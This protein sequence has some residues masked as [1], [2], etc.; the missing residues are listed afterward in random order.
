[1]RRLFKKKANLLVIAISAATVLIPALAF[2][3]DDVPST[4]RLT[5]TNG[6]IQSSEVS[7][8]T[9]V[10]AQEVDGT[11]NGDKIVFWNGVGITY[12]WQGKTADPSWKTYQY[13]SGVTCDNKSILMANPAHPQ[14]GNTGAN[15]WAN[16][17]NVPGVNCSGVNINLNKFTYSVEVPGTI[18]IAHPENADIIY[19][20]SGN[21][22]VR[23]DGDPGYVFVPSGHANLK[24]VF[25]KQN[26]LSNKCPD[27][28]VIDPSVGDAPGN[29]V[30]YGMQVGNGG[31]PPPTTGPFAP[32]AASDCTINPD[33]TNT[34]VLNSAA[35]G[36]ASTPNPSAPKLANGSIKLHI[37]GVNQSTN[38]D[39]TAGPTGPSPSSD[40]NAS[41]CN[42]ASSFAWVICPAITT[43]TNLTQ[44]IFEN[45]LIPI[46][47][48]SPLNDPAN[49]ALRIVW[50]IFRSLADVFFVVI[51]LIMIFGTAI[52]TGIDSY[53]VKKVLPRLVIAAILVQ[54]SYFICGLVIDIGNVLGVG[55]ITLFNGA[56][57]GIPGDPNAH[58]AANVF[59]NNLGLGVVLAGTAGILVWLAAPMLLFMLLGLLISIVTFLVTLILR[60]LLINVLVV[61]SPVAFVLWVLPNTEKLFKMWLNNFTKV[62]MMFPMMA[63][64]LGAGVLVRAVS[65]AGGNQINQL[66]GLVAP[67]IAFCMMPMTFKWAGSAMSG[68]GKVVGGRG[69]ALNSKAQNSQLA[70]DA[71]ANSKAKSALKYQNASGLNKLMRG[72]A[73]GGVGGMLGTAGS[74]RRI[75]ALASKHEND[76]GDQ[77]EEQIRRSNGGLGFETGDYTKFLE[78]KEVKGVKSTPASRKRALQ[79]AAKSGRWDEIRDARASGK[80]DEAT[81]AQ[82]LQGTDAAVKAPDLVRKAPGIDG[83]RASSGT[84]F[85]GMHHSTK[86]R[87]IDQLSTD[88]LSG[89]PETKTKGENTLASIIQ[90]ADADP[91]SIDIETQ[92]R[93]W[94]VVSTGTAS[95]LSPDQ[96]DAIK[97]RYEGTSGM[98][99]KKVAEVTV[100]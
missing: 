5:A 21:N 79:M 89:D 94:D 11:I 67:I 69:A 61:L 90:A 72:A 84:Q 50:G 55:I 43:V 8:W 1:V 87:T 33:G 99:K 66:I 6:Q 58:A 76:Q 46:L 64:L 45:I 88:L 25:V 54:F 100:V 74:K 17:P 68:V 41:A 37:S 13:P 27:E 3:F 39:P 80:L 9:W 49:S 86:K 85:A 92:R 14:S 62:V 38:I 30:L 57:S 34:D 91:G 15:I 7:G 71:K 26:Q 4:G 35:E 59:L 36:T 2:A 83:L 22:I 40:N 16:Q 98:M 96:I 23:V 47:Q 56:V 95:G 28:I 51:F 65:V 10:N 53:T 77:Y 18:K 97:S 42:D 73:V 12:Y 63:L 31:T 24:N 29:A 52:S 60:L 93:L 70:K 20:L 75:A 32:G 81:L 19:K 48:V 78:G 82:G 44:Y